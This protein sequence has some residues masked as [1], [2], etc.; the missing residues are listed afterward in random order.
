MSSLVSNLQMF[1]YVI[2]A[3]VVLLF[4]MRWQNEKKC[5]DGILCRFVSDEGN[6]YK[7]FMPVI[8]GILHIVPDKK[9][10]GAEY[11][12]SSLTTHNVNYPETAVFPFNFA[13]VSVKECWFDERTA[14]PL[15]NRS[16]MLLVTPNALYNMN[17]ERFTEQA[18]GK[19]QLEQYE[20]AAQSKMLGNVQPHKS[21]VNMK[22]ILIMVGIF[23]LAIAGVAI[24]MHFKGQNAPTLGL[25]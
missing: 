10:A 9:R 8:N 17:T 21:G 14:E 1:A 22:V 24:Y 5:K 23:G 3:F 4:F 11:A 18:S 12:V 16:P 13:Q 2:L 15:S 20:I 6:G 25:P 7:K 19:S